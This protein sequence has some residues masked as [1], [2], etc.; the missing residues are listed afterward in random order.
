MADDIKS[1][2]DLDPQS[3][4]KTGVHLGTRRLFSNPKMKP[5]I[6]ATKN[7]FQIIDLEKTAETFESA[8][9]FLENIRKSNGVILIVGTSVAAREA[10]LKFAKE[11]NS[12][13]V[14]DRWLGGTLTNWPTISGRIN[15]LKDL[16]T[17][18]TSGD[19]EKYTKY[20]TQKMEEKIEKL[21]KDLGG[22]KTMA[23]LPNVVWVCS[24]ASDKIAVLEARKKNIPVIG[25][26]NT[27]TDPT[28]LDYPIP[29]N[30]SAKSAVEYI[31]ELIG[32]RLAGI[33]PTLPQEDDKAKVTEQTH[34]KN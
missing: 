17:R 8:L 32:S 24:G 14:T 28:I 23:K 12:P 27:N 34:G 25:L 5:Y 30:D 33:T 1:E 4:I 11:L 18:K 22:L 26:V 10:V 15:Y 31:I 7:T 19:F 21:N 29:C 6:W 20:E 3:M 2:L 9:Q 16:E 13:F